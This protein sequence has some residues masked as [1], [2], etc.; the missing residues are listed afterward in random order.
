MVLVF[1]PPNSLLHFGHHEVQ[2]GVFRIRFSQMNYERTYV[3]HMLESGLL[4]GFKM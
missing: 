3:G 4:I 1:T 2:R